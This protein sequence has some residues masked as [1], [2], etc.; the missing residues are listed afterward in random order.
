MQEKGFEKLGNHRAVGTKRFVFKL[1]LGLL[2]FVGI[3]VYLGRGKDFALLSPKGG[4]SSDQFSL[5][6]FFAILL[7]LVALLALSTLYYFV[8]KYRVTDS[9]TNPATTD[10]KK[11]NGLLLWIFPILLAIF[12]SSVLWPAT[13][14]LAPQKSLAEGVEPLRIQVVALP[15]K[16]LF[17][18]PDQGVATVNYVQ[19]PANTPIRFDLTADQMPMSSFWIP[20]LGGQLYT[21]TG[22]HNILNLIAQESGTYPGS[23]AEINGAGFA[24]MKFDVQVGTA[25]DFDS[26]VTS[27]RA[28]LAKLSSDEYSKLTKPSEN[29]AAQNFVYDNND[30]LFENVLA[31]YDHG[32]NHHETNQIDHKEHQ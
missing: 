24:D 1:T 13:R 19:I 10:K 9:N 4:I 14:R 22:H 2:V 30:D 15:W 27:T 31:K 12:V 3:F 28:S 25:D 29:N 23:S 6:R 8:W 26:W 11:I 32:N 21:M 20:H 16:W 7:T 5:L 18:Y 17:I